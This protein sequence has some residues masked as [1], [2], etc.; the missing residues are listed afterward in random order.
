MDFGGVL[1]TDLWASVRAC[2]RREG[3]PADTLVNL[4]HNDLH[5]LFADLERGAISQT[6]FEKQL[7]AAAGLAP[8]G[9]LGR[10]CADLRPDEA[11]LAAVDKLRGSGIKVGILSNSW[12]TGP[13]GEGYFDPYA[14]YDLP[15]RADAIV[16]SDIVG[17]RKPEPAIFDLMLR[18]VGVTARD[19][20][21]VDDVAANLPPAE[22]IGMRTIHH[23]ETAVTIAELETLF[24]ISL[25]G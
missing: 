21:F 7:A 22:A 11:M 2:S 17:L 23:V 24:A 14:G 12:G 4:L 10:M 13:W 5:E 3:L 15:N 16:L 1:T 8:E 25:R 19:A 9:L 18:Q 20:V 6:E